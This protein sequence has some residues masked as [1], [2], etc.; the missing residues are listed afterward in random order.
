MINPCTHTLTE[1]ILRRFADIFT[2]LVSKAGTMIVMGIV[3]YVQQS[4]LPGTAAGPAGV[5][6]EGC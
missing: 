5:R 4:G 6:R 3:S 1:A 2:P